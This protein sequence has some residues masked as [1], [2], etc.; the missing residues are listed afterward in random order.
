MQKINVCISDSDR[1]DA[2]KFVKKKLPKPKKLMSYCG[3]YMVH[4]TMPFIF[5][6]HKYGRD[7]HFNE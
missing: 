7:S 4:I 3:I 2:Y 5:N 1:H 6:P